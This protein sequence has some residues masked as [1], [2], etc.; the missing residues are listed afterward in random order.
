MKKFVVILA[1]CALLLTS[2]TEKDTYFAD[3]YF[4]MNTV[5]EIVSDEK[6]SAP[7]VYEKICYYENI[8]SRTKEGSEIYSLNQKGEGELSDEA[9]YVLEKAIKIANDTNCAFNPCMGTLTELWNITSGEKYVPSEEETEK[10][11][12]YCDISGVK[13]DGNHVSIPE[14]MKIDL[15]GVAK[16]YALQKSLSFESAENLCVSLGGNVG[17]VGSS[18]TLKKQSKKGWTVGITNPFDKQ[19]TVGELVLCEK[20]VAVSGAYERYF[21]KDGKIYHHI[22]DSNT[23][24]PAESDIA[25]SVIISSDG[26]EADALSTALFVMGKERSIEFYQSGKYD[27]DMILITNDGELLVSE[28]VYDNFTADGSENIKKEIIK[29]AKG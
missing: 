2:C 7:S 1:L 15:G 22:F 29:I 10:A 24:Y 23:G 4:A 11:K 8:F 14:G 6:E 27:F 16:G 25:S 17:V 5:V 3:T 12:S 9:L 26:L 18:Q 21:E 28:G 13:I 19:T 20:F